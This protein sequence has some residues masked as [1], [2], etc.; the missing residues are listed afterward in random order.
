M[1][2]PRA[3]HTLP[4]RPFRCDIRDEPLPLARLA[5]VARSGGG[6]FPQSPL[7]RRRQSPPTENA[8]FPALFSTFLQRSPGPQTPSV[9]RQARSPAPQSPAPFS[10][11]SAWASG[12]APCT[13]PR[14]AATHQTTAWPRRSSPS[15]PPPHAAPPR[16]PQAAPST[17]WRTTEVPSHGAT[18]RTVC[19]VA[20]G[21][22]RPPVGS[23]SSPARP[24]AGYERHTP[25][26]VEEPR[27]LRAD[28]PAEPVHG[29][30]EN[31]T[32]WVPRDVVVPRHFGTDVRLPCV[33]CWCTAAD[34]NEATAA[35][36][37]R[38]S[39]STASVSAWYAR[40]NSGCRRLCG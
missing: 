5:N 14:R 38:A 36:A 20:R 40:L 16:A 30:A 15:P 32:V 27:P 33:P 9:R 1:P 2:G 12:T 13:V 25:P 7:R 18:L 31:A 22:T 39:A 24:P 4:T 3:H 21:G 29:T 6:A 26:P 8:P 37:D 34:R 35:D 19:E 11:P 17:S 23:G 28:A 10:S